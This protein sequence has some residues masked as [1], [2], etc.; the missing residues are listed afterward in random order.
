M[1]FEEFAAGRQ[2]HDALTIPVE[3]DDGDR[4]LYD[5]TDPA[6]TGVPLL[7]VTRYYEEI[8]QMMSNPA[9]RLDASLFDHVRD[10]LQAIGWTLSRGAPA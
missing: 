3:G 6:Q 1:P 4:S 8:D 9:W 7:I 5:E 2:D 10:S